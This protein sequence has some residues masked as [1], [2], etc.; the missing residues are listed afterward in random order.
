MNMNQNQKNKYYVCL[1]GNDQTPVTIEES[2]A[3][4]NEFILDYNFNYF[5]KIF[6]HIEQVSSESGLTF[7]VTRNVKVLPSYG[8]DVV[9]ILLGDE[10]CRIPRY[11]DKVKAVFKC[12]GTKP[13]IGYYPFNQPIS[14]S[15]MTLIQFIRVFLIR[16]PGILRYLFYS[17]KNFGVR[18]SK[19]APVYEIPLGFY[20]QE[21]LPIKDFLSRDYDTYFRGSMINHEKL[22]LYFPRFSLKSPKNLSRDRMIE[23]LMLLKNKYPDINIELFLIDKFLHGESKIASDSYSLDMMNTKICLVPRGTSFETFRFFEGL[24]YG[25]IVITETLPKHWFYEGSPAIHIK[26]WSQLDDVLI[27]LISSKET[28]LEKH[29]ASLNWWDSKCSEAAVGDYMASKLNILMPTNSQV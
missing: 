12:Y 1:P 4:G 29:K 8:Q 18:N 28:M 7:Y 21:D 11:F 24:R 2:I 25:C 26:D 3:A 20:K 10:W 5:K 15:T 13:V 22:Q 6:D 9:A 17:V 19:L 23:S 16:L 14:L 27:E